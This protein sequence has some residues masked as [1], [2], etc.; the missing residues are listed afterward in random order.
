MPENLKYYIILIAI[1]TVILLGVF[2]ITS[3]TQKRNSES[4]KITHPAWPV[5]GDYFNLKN[6]KLTLPKD[7]DEIDGDP[8]EIEQ[9]DLNNFTNEFFFFE[10]EKGAMVFKAPVNGGKTDN[11]NYSRSELRELPNNGDWK[12]SEGTHSMEIEQA[13]THLPI[14]KPHVVIGQIHDDDDDVYVFRLEGSKL[15]AN[16]DGDDNDITFTD[17][18]KLK[19]KFKVKFEVEN[20]ETKVYYNDQLMH[21]MK[22]D[23]SDAYFKTGAYVQ[24][25]CTYSSS[26]D[27]EKENCGDEDNIPYAQVEI[28]FLEICHNGKCE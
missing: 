5:P 22:K 1:S 24:A 9:P 17:S 14:N 6:W 7:T 28:Y 18:Y 23:Y 3:N 11:T 12:S 19:D 26:D 13:V 21:T 8:D 25:S 15:Y 4:Q 16:A 10:K 2:K 27:F 20:N